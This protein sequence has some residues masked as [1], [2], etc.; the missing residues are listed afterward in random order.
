ME[1]SITPCRFNTRAEW[2][3]W[4]QDNYD[5]KKEAWF[6]FP[7]KASGEN[8]VSYNDAVEEAL[9]FGWIDSTVKALDDTHK[10]QKFSP[11]NP[12]SSYSQANKERLL[13]LSKEG[14]IHPMF[15]ESVAK[16]LN[17]EFVYP[18]DILEAIKKDEIAWRYF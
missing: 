10:I 17:E 6:V 18:K 1:N 4:L 14:L 9:C 3:E 5:K 13:W 12:K 11:R 15:K 16:I 8:A 2:R 7:L